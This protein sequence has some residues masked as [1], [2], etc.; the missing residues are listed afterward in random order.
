VF[1]LRS[2]EL[3]SVD[4]LN[5]CLLRA[6]QN[7]QG[8]TIEILVSLDRHRN[9]LSRWLR[10]HLFTVAG[11]RAAGLL[12]AEGDDSKFVSSFEWPRSNCR[13]RMPAARFQSTTM[14]RCALHVERVCGELAQGLAEHGAGFR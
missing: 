2:V 4:Q 12:P 5:M 1:F 3:N 11:H 6:H 9:F 14:K 13:Q 7:I 8:L 10:A